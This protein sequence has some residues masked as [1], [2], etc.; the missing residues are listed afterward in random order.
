MSHLGPT[1]S[2]SFLCTPCS[3]LLCPSLPQPQQGS[4]IP[5]RLSFPFCKH[6]MAITHTAWLLPHKERREC[7]MTDPSVQEWGAD[8]TQWALTKW[9]P[10]PVP[11]LSRAPTPPLDQFQPPTKKKKINKSLHLAGGVPDGVGPL[12]PASGAACLPLS[13]PLTCGLWLLVAGL[14]SLR[15]A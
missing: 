14:S 9:P 1:L 13:L 7:S 6:P 2:I 11:R 12:S 3:S 8:R 5:L 15:K 10:P 4:S